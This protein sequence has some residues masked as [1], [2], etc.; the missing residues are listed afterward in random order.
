MEPREPNISIWH[1]FRLHLS[2]E[3]LVYPGAFKDKVCSFGMK[4]A[5]YRAGL[6]G[7]KV[8]FDD[9]DKIYHRYIGQI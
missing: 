8:S 1:E 5:Q 2:C 7:Y 4:I 9:N 3:V 6:R